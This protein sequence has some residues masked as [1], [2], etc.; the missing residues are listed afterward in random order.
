VGQ[1]RFRC[2]L[3]VRTKDEPF[4]QLGILLDSDVHYANPNLV[5]RYFTQPSILR[6]FGWRVIIVLAKDWFHEPDAVLDRIERILRNQSD[7]DPVDDSELE[8]VATEPPRNARAAVAAGNSAEPET[9]ARVSVPDADGEKTSSPPGSTTTAQPAAASAAQRF[10]YVGVG[11]R[12]L[13]EISVSGAE[14]SVRFGRIGTVGQEQIK[15]FSD[16]ARAQREADKLITEKLKK[17][18]SEVG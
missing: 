6:T 3:A 1:S 16:A 17:G 4:Y 18:Y 14:V 5:E 11:S 2:D 15:S 13:W 7:D 12:K 10:E 9:A 8:P